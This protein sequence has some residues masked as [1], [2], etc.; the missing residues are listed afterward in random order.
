[1]IYILINQSSDVLFLLALFNSLCSFLFKTTSTAGLFV[2]V[3]LGSVAFTGGLV[4]VG[5]TSGL[6]TGSSGTSISMLLST[7]SI[8]KLSTCAVSTTIR[9][10]TQIYLRVIS[11]AGL[12]NGPNVMPVDGS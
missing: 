11:T 5:L 12:G 1:M 2:V 3:G 10:L 7:E 8:F 9:G 4:S 6:T